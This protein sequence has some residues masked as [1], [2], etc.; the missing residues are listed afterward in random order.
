[1]LIAP[2]SPQINT[3]NHTSLK[4]W[5]S[6][7][8]RHQDPS[9]PFPSPLK[10][11]RVCNFIYPSMRPPVCSIN[12]YSPPFTTLMI[13]WGPANFLVP[14][15]YVLHHYC[16]FFLLFFVYFICD[17]HDCFWTCF[18]WILVFHAFPQDHDHSHLQSKFDS[19]HTFH[20]HHTLFPFHVATSLLILHLTLQ[21]IFLFQL[22]ILFTP[23][24]TT[25][26]P[27]H[28]FTTNMV[29]ALQH[30]PMDDCTLCHDSSA[31]RGTCIFFIIHFHHHHPTDYVTDFKSPQL[32]LGKWHHSLI[33]EYATLEGA[34]CD[35]WTLL[36]SKY[37]H[38]QTAITSLFL[39]F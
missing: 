4:G 9:R 8:E 32:S 33:M 11:R 10:P 38:S 13:P 26:T 14:A 15:L 23:T 3:D 18:T 19:H 30:S 21:L 27:V 5:I 1:M 22:S 24:N 28:L 35:N 17:W 29:P 31:W 12:F 37:F 2:S 39:Y 16:Q 34:C 36:F 7:S 6:I 20:L 25:F